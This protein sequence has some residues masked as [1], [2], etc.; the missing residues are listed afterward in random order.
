M[1]VISPKESQFFVNK[2]IDNFLHLQSFIVF[3]TT[4]KCDNYF[5]PLSPSS[6]WYTVVYMPYT[7][8]IN[9]YTL[10]IYSVQSLVCKL[11]LYSLFFFTPTPLVTLYYCYLLSCCYIKVQLHLSSINLLKR[12]PQKFGH[13]WMKYQENSLQMMN[14]MKLE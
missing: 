5:L 14:G 13:Q 12:I 6:V 1:R 7:F 3:S 9:Q 11:C 2:I 10:H 8:W 4:L